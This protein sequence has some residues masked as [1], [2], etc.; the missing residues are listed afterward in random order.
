MRHCIALPSI[1]FRFQRTRRNILSFQAASALHESSISNKHNFHQQQQP[2]YQ[3]I[4]VEFSFEGRPPK[5]VASNGAAVPFFE[6][7]IV[8]F[9]ATCPHRLDDKHILFS[10]FRNF[11]H[12]IRDAASENSHE[13][14][15]RARSH[16]RQTFIS[17]SPSGLS[18]HCAS[19]S[20]WNFQMVLRSI[21]AVSPFIRLVVALMCWWLIR[22]GIPNSF[23]SYAE[24]RNSHEIVFLRRSPHH[25]ILFGR[26]KAEN[27][28]PLRLFPPPHTHTQPADTQ[29]EVMSSNKCCGRHFPSILARREAG[30]V[31]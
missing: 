4:F 5:Y 13:I 23:E 14:N 2:V 17:H 29:V 18:W 15:S 1:L 7:K 27:I 16:T 11:F 6:R 9:T 25:L 12:S 21:F 3:N 31:K 26:R 8:L 22:P 20:I 28:P 30:E 24:H 19:L 10:F